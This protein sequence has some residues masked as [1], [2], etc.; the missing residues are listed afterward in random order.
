MARRKSYLHII[1]QCSS[2][3]PELALGTI[4]QALDVV[5]VQQHHQP[6]YDY[7]P[8]QEQIGI[9]LRKMKSVATTAPVVAPR[10]DP[11]ET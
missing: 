7:G 8:G 5:V 10:I 9:R 3:L 2:L 6:G 4:Q 1:T 11:R